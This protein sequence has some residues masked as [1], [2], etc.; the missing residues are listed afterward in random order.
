[1]QYEDSAQP[2][3]GVKTATMKDVA[4]LAGVS[5]GTVDRVFHNRGRF[6][7]DTARRVWEAARSLRFQPNRV[8]SNLSRA[9]HYTLLALL[10]H[11]EQDGGFWKLVVA[12]ITRAVEEL[13]HHYVNVRFAHYDRFDPSSFEHAVAEVF[14]RSDAGRTRG[15]RIRGMVLAP[16]L[17]EEVTRFLTEY[18]ALPTVVLDGEVPDGTVLCSISQES[19]ESGLL[20]AK[21]LHLLSRGGRVASVTVG[22][23]DYHLNRRRAGFEAYFAGCRGELGAP[24]HDGRAID[25][26]RIEAY[27][28]RHLH[29]VVRRRGLSDEPPLEGV[30]VTNSAA[31]AVVAALRATHV[32]P[33]VGYDLIP[34]NIACLRNGELSFLINQQP[35]NQGYEAVYALYRHLVLKEAVEPQRRIPVDLVSRETLRFHYSTAQVENTFT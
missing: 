32:P 19:F 9:E 21:M 22:Q 5:I 2:E 29:E 28:E 1:M 16:T 13:A 10:P 8:A 27:D 23:D 30:F 33:V 31:H 20:A 15:Q 17:Q 34:E 11:P 24:A 12:G 3:A 26:E 6:S 14:A 7:P 25:V 35:G 4:L 18:E